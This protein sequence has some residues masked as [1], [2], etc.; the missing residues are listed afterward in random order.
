M[1][2]KH[3]DNKNNEIKLIEPYSFIP[4]LNPNT[5]KGPPKNDTQE[6]ATNRLKTFNAFINTQKEITSYINSQY[7]NSQNWA[8]IHDLCLELDGN[9]ILIDHLIINRLLQCYI[10]ESKNLGPKIKI[11]NNT[12]F[13]LFYNNEE[14]KIDSPIERN[15]LHK[16]FM[17][18]FIDKNIIDLLTKN[19][20]SIKP[21]FYGF[22]AVAPD[23]LIEFPTKNIAELSQIVKID[24]LL[25]DINQHYST[26]S[27]QYTLMMKK[28]VSTKILEEFAK[29]LT[30]HHKPI[31]IDHFFAFKNKP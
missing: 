8:I 23:A 31:P 26:E 12:E 18:K 16:L 25:N 29:E 4:N 5:S 30:K 2:I 24:S 1:I 27:L 3:S 14:L 19:G 9:A 21:E 7:L 10:I 11:N 13:S 6:Q 20:I 28:A 22:V 15:K 17:Q